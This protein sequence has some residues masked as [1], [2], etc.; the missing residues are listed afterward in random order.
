MYRDGAPIDYDG[1]RAA[2]ASVRVRQPHNFHFI[3]MNRLL[4]ERRACVPIGVIAG[5]AVLA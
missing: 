4:I 2:L 5:L 1:L 3:Q